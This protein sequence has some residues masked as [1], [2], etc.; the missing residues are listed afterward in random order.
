MFGISKK[1]DKLGDKI[2]PITNGANAS[3]D[4]GTPPQPEPVATSAQTEPSANA[5][6]A[7]GQTPPRPAE[8]ETTSKTDKSGAADLSPDELKRRAAATKLVS[9][10]FGQVVS[11]L[12]R[13]P[14]YKHYSLADL[15]WMVVPAIVTSQ[16]SIVEAQS[17][18]NGLS[19]PVCVVL[20]AHVSD[21]VDQRLS[22]TPG[23]PIRLKPHE[24][25]SGEKLWVID[26]IGDA[27]A[28]GAV[29]NRLRANEWKGKAVR[30]RTRGAD[31]KPV[32]RDLEP[33][34]SQTPSSET[35]P[36]VLN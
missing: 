20:W 10:A 34:Q 18:K 19:A 8:P 16:F 14:H 12:M 27:R 11:V 13:A 32:V 7:P 24:W 22:S 29:I 5:G 17:R 3:V 6:P 9:A 2:K 36:P 23:E 31:G 30:M 25:R 4:T 35:P 28:V 21:E 33:L 26:A 15:E 1:K